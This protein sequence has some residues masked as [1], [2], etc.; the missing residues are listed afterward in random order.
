MSKS[1]L[2]ANPAVTELAPEPISR[3]WVLSGT[4][5][6]S[7]RVLAE[8]RDSLLKLVVWECTPGRFEWHYA[9]DE[10][11]FVLSGEAVIRD[12][13]G[14][15]RFAAGDVVYFPAGSSCTWLVK[16]HIRKVAILRE[17]L[18]RPFGVA[19]AAWAKALRLARVAFHRIRTGAP[20]RNQRGGA[21]AGKN[22]AA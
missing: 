8:S 19:I 13:Q 11:V 16:D 22:A 9:K 15:R 4:P 10:I 1:I 7:S 20:L 12:Q 3:D 14:E 21:A 18:W 2:I 6:G 5:Q 17:T